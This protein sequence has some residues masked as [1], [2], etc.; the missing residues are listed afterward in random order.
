VNRDSALHNDNVLRAGLEAG[1]TKFVCAVGTGPG[2]VRSQAVIPTT[3]PDETLDR[4]AGFFLEARR[5]GLDFDALGIASFGPLD[6]TPTSPSYGQ[7]TTT[8][9][10][11]WAGTDLVGTLGRR[12]HVPVTL[13]TDVNG[14]AYGEFRWGAGRGLHSS[15]Y[16]TVGTGIGGGAVIGGEPL[17]GLGHP[18]MGHL[19]VERHPSDDFAGSCPFHGD[20]LEGMASGPAIRSR[21]GRSPEQLG[22]DHQQVVELEAWYVGQLVSAVIY[23]LSPQVIILGGG[24]LQ[25][26]GLMDA[27]RASVLKRLSGALDGV[28]M[29]ER[30]DQYIVPPGLGASS[31]VLGA[32]ALAEL[33]A[34]ALTPVPD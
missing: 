8:P 27:V 13:D 18:E 24:V 29:V 9:K 22:R 33:A 2:D 34:A 28:D 31:G 21:S 19:H 5:S 20:C 14:A 6:L 30:I 26:E 7:I 3:T 32:L 25:L 4:V 15:A 17:R 23:L 16:L 1:G 11:G 12:L 10:A